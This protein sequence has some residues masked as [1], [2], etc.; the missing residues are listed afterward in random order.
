M[1]IDHW[2]LTILSLHSFENALRAKLEMKCPPTSDNATFLN[3]TFK[4]FDIQN[5]GGVNQDQF[6]RAV[7][8]MGVVLTDKMVSAL[9][10]LLTDAANNVGYGYYLRVL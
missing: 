10:R 6:Q 7:E 1:I 4:F 2:Y 8:K 9:S 5:K 3:K